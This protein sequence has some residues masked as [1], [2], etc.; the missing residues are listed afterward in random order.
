MYMLRNMG[1]QQ[2]QFQQQYQPTYQQQQPSPYQMGQ[3]FQ[4][5]F[6]PMAYGPPQPIGNEFYGPQVNFTSFYIYNPESVA[7][8]N[9]IR[10]RFDPGDESHTHLG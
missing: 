5:P 7:W 3:E 1:P 10:T 6:L 8:L 4:Q 9:D 2:F